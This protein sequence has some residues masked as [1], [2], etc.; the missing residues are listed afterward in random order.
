MPEGGSLAGISRV[1][2][3]EHLAC[4]LGGMF[5]LGARVFDNPEDLEVAKRLAEGFVWAYSAMPSGIM[6][7][8]AEIMECKED[9]A[10]CLYTGEMGLDGGEGA[11]QMP[12]NATN[13]ERTRQSAKMRTREGLCPDCTNVIDSEYKLR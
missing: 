10:D 4:F 11:G 8:F 1:Y 3:V 9:G 13:S 5:G 12:V 6:P 2:D 7:E